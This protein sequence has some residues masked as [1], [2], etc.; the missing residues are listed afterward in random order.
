MIDNLGTHAENERLLDAYVMAEMNDHGTEKD[1]VLKAVLR[2]QVLAK[3]DGSR[4]TIVYRDMPT[5]PAGGW[6]P[7][8]IGCTR[9]TLDGSEA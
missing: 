5:I 3:M 8:Y 9:T 7:N 1:D 6:Q 2:E 4:N